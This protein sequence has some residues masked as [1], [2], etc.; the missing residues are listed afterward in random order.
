M[1]IIATKIKMYFVL[2]TIY[3]YHH[4]YFWTTA[5]L[6]C[7][8]RAFFLSR[9][10]CS[11]P[12]SVYLRFFSLLC[13]SSNLAA[14][15]SAVS[16]LLCSLFLLATTRFSTYRAKMKS[17]DLLSSPAPTPTQIHRQISFPN[18]LMLN[19][20]YVTKKFWYKKNFEFENVSQ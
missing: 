9:A 16:F 14:C 2:T 3:H 6:S 1:E 15:R 10:S 18:L 13:T 5:R 4:H 8:Y 17:H 7:Y 19:R 12:M 20:S 11:F